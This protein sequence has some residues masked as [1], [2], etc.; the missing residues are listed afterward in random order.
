MDSAEVTGP[1][2]FPRSRQTRELFARGRF[3]ATFRERIIWHFYRDGIRRLFIRPWRRSWRR[4]VRRRARIFWR[5]PRVVWHRARPLNSPSYLRRHVNC[6][7]CQRFVKATTITIRFFLGAIF[8]HAL[9]LFSAISRKI[10]GM[11]QIDVFANVFS[12]NWQ[13]GINFFTGKRENL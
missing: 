6:R 11:L 5:I 9:N 1:S 12:S 2:H 4:D 13:L 10:G 3:R 8:I 7:D